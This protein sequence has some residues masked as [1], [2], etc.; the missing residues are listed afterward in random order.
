MTRRFGGKRHEELTWAAPIA[1]LLHSIV[2][3]ESGAP[4]CALKLSFC[5]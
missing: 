1:V 4:E 5:V 2:H 3:S